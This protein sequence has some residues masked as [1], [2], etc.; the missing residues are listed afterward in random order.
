VEPER[1]GEKMEVAWK[2]SRRGQVDNSKSDV[3][4]VLF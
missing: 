4:V 2:R 1:G 3:L